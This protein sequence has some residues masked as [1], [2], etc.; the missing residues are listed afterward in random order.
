MDGATRSYEG[1][2]GR[3]DGAGE[4]SRYALGLPKS[5]PMSFGG[6]GKAAMELAASSPTMPESLVFLSLKLLPGG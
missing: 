3:V 1:Q 5:Y 6:A 2:L 4:E